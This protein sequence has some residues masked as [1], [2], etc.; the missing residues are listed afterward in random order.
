MKGQILLAAI[1]IIMSIL[2]FS[3]LTGLQ[4]SGTSGSLALI[5]SQIP[6]G[7]KHLL[8]RQLAFIQID[9]DPR[10]NLLHLQYGQEGYIMTEDV[11]VLPR[12]EA[13]HPGSFTPHYLST[14][15]FVISADSTLSILSYNDLINSE[16]R[17]YFP[18]THKTRILPAIDMALADAGNLSAAA[19]LLMNLKVEDKLII[20]QYADEYEDW[21][22]NNTVA[23]MPDDEAAQLILSGLPLRIIVPTEGTLSFTV[24]LYSPA[25]S[26][27]PLLLDSEDLVAAG[28]R[29]LD[30]SADPAIYPQPDQYNLAQPAISAEN[31]SQLAHGTVKIFR[32]KILGTHLYSTANGSER[33]LLNIP[34][35]LAVVFWGVSLFWRVVDRK[36]RRLLQL[37]TVLLLFWVLLL[38]LKQSSDMLLTRY[39]WYLYYL[40]L[41]GSALILPLA[42]L[43]IACTPLQHRQKLQIVLIM[44]S[45]LL[46]VLILS[47][48]L[49]QW[50][51]FFP[52]GLPRYD[53][54]QHATGFYA[55]AT[56]LTFLL[57]SG[58]LRLYRC[59]G[60]RRKGRF[61]LLLSLLIAIVIGYNALYV[62]GIQA[63]R[64]TQTGTVHIVSILLF[65]EL[66]LRGGLIPYNRH[67][68][69][70][71]QFSRLPLF[72]LQ[73]DG[74]VLQS[75]DGA[76][77]LSAEIR[78]DILEGKRLFFT[79]DDIDGVLG[80]DYEVSEITGGFVV[81]KNDLHYIRQLNDSLQKIRQRLL[82]QTSLLEKEVEQQRAA[83]ELSA[84]RQLLEQ[85]DQ[86]IQPRLNEVSILSAR[87][88]PSVAKR[89]L[90]ITLQDIIRLIGY[91]KRIG[92]I[93]INALSV[94]SVP[95][96]L[97]LML[98]QETCADRTGRGLEIALFGDL[99]GDFSL[100]EAVLYLDFFNELLQ[101]L[102]ECDAGT[103]VIHAGV[104]AGRQDIV[105]LCDVPAGFV[106]ILEDYAV[107]WQIK[108]AETSFTLLMIPE[109][110]SL[111]L[112]LRQKG[113]HH[114]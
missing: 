75:T 38:I 96:K 35:A 27:L 29:T 20:G 82:C 50:V 90:E 79:P 40:P 110:P 68:R 78:A 84:R 55:T 2:L 52:E 16:A 112:V 101:A 48:D 71:F 106:K 22:D 37:Q 47:N 23:L 39:L 105:F 102:R 88:S 100:S 49:H 17:L 51:F 11:R 44:P 8:T 72:L 9:Q 99:S 36:V 54:Y 60:S 25:T 67:Y 76:A 18:E 4:P 57:F 53:P 30:G 87:L 21:L 80:A 103:I 98:L 111:R 69:I 95:A 85:L 113:V 81:W 109:S 62:A 5:S 31:Y 64:Q 89:D 108:L 58:L 114:D 14:I 10:K 33:V 34:L 24:G 3:S 12:L 93:H 94:S 70:L 1:L 73:R 15:V 74:T 92:L 43:N 6:D 42:S 104:P 45:I 86:L 77:S 19:D 59:A 83:Q 56:W 63:I 13:G 107:D 91:C 61:I 46:V 32:R 65:W 66:T 28:L 97:L 41:L 7:Y 26:M